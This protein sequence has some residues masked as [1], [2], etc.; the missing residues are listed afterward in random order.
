MAYRK[1]TAR[2]FTL[3][4]LIIVIAILAVLAALLIPAT[5]GYLSTA[6]QQAC[7]SNRTTARRLLYSGSALHKLEG[8]DAVQYLASGN[9]PLDAICPAGGVIT[10]K[11]GSDGWMLSCSIHKDGGGKP[12]IEIINEHIQDLMDRAFADYFSARP[13]SKDLDS[14]G[15]NFGAAIR[16]DLAGLLDIPADQADQYDFRIYHQALNGKNEYYVYVFDSL[17]GHSLGDRIA[18]TRYVFQTGTDGKPVL[19]KKATTMGTGKVSTKLVDGKDRIKFLDTSEASW[20][21]DS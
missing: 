3:I 14:T 7:L 2:G 8:E 20:Q 21:Q 11:K 19:D 16:S 4:E 12:A 9:M 13:S 17:S 1:K 18:A 10:V 15:P 6:Q 5:L